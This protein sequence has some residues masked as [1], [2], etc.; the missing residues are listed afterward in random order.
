MWS[1]FWF[2]TWLLLK[3]KQPHISPN[4]EAISALTSL[5]LYRQIEKNVHYWFVVISKGGSRSVGWA[6]LKIVVFLFWVSLFSG[7]I[8]P[9]NLCTS[10]WSLQGILQEP[11]GED[12]PPGGPAVLSH[13]QHTGHFPNAHEGGHPQAPHCCG[14]PQHLPVPLPAWL[15]PW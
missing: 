3:P 5:C 11:L 8:P 6:D 15:G 9:S 4:G 13:F 10:P 14:H 2:V 12:G 1:F 7:G